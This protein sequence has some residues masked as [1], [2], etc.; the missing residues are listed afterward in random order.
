MAKRILVVEDDPIT[1]RT[2]AFSIGAVNALTLIAT[3]HSVAEAVRF[4]KAHPVDVCLVDMG[5]P[6]GSG[7]EVIRCAAACLPAVHTLVVS[8]FGDES[9][10]ISAIEA[11]ASGYILKD[12]LTSSVASEIETLLSGG[13]PL[14]PMVAK[15]L[16]SKF[17][18]AARPPT[19][20]HETVKLTVRETEVL[21][22]IAKGCAYSEV[23]R[24]LKIRFE[25]VA[26][27]LRN[28]Y[29]KLSVHSRCE[30]VY[31]AS[32]MGLIKF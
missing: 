14:S 21:N 16:L 31:E 10:V 9:N 4:L 19:P 13:S 1:A 15:L 26:T 11:G 20:A 5:L 27:H 32:R 3:V 28:I 23:A 8:I 7:L 2:F 30:A 29:E 25:T 17:R 18:V 22:L 6:D 24:V 12:A